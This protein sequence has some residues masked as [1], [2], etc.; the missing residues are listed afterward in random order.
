MLRSVAPSAKSHNARSESPRPASAPEQAHPL[1][2]TEALLQ[3][4]MKRERR[5]RMDAEEREQKLL[6]QISM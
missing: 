5:R 6:E 1:A 3:D 4:M 2:E